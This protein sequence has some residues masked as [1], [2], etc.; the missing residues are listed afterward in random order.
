[1]KFNRRHF[2]ST[3]AIGSTGTVGRAVSAQSEIQITGSIDSMVGAT[4]SGV[5]LFFSTGRYGFGVDL[6]GSRGWKYRVHCFRNRY[7]QSQT[8]EYLKSQ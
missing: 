3:L 1:M 6:Y 7:L 5:E 4:V 2:C 8:V